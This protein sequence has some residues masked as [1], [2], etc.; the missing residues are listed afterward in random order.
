MK[1]QTSSPFFI[2]HFIYKANN[3]Q[4][5]ASGILSCLA[6][7]RVR[8]HMRRS[9]RY[10]LRWS[11][12]GSCLRKSVMRDNPDGKQQHIA[13][14]LTD[15]PVAST[16][17]LNEVTKR[18]IPVRCV[19]LARSGGGAN[20]LRCARPIHG[21][22]QRMQN[23][24]GYLLNGSERSQAAAASSTTQ[25][26][27]HIMDPFRS[28]IFCAPRVQLPAAARRDPL[29][30]VAHPRRLLHVVP[31]RALPGSSCDSAIVW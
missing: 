1:G 20:R 24:L 16:G 27:N 3:M 14:T 23:F 5:S 26:A 18:H 22:E 4:Q 29:N 17:S 2:R 7:S 30:P 13:D 15:K 10:R 28:R 19:C 31:T 11:H 21:R 9:P 8:I 12:R 6:A 25:I